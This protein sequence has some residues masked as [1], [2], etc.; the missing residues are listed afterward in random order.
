MNFFTTG[1]YARIWKIFQ[2][3]VS[4][5]YESCGICE[6]TYR[7]T[8]WLITEGVKTNRFKKN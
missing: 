8:M 3:K 4:L 2:R 7:G 1:E 5:D 6:S